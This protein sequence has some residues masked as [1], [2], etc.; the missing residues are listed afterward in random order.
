MK[1]E[2]VLWFIKNIA[3]R[4]EI[5]FDTPG[6]ITEE[7]TDKGK[8][9]KIRNFLVPEIFISDLEKKMDPQ[10]SYEIGKKFGY[11]YAQLI[12]APRIT[13][14]NPQLFASFLYF[15]VRY[16]GSLLAS[17]ASHTW[18]AQNRIFSL[19]MKDYVVCSKNGL[20]YILTEGT[21]AGTCAYMFDDV[22]IE[23][24]Q[25]KCQGRGDSECFLVA[26]S[27]E[28]LEKDGMKPL[29][30]PDV[31]KNF[32]YD[33][34]YEHM[35]SIHIPKWG[36]NSFKKL[37]DSGFLSFGYGKMEY[38]KERF[39]LFEASLLYILEDELTKHD[40]K[41]QSLLDTLWDVSFE[42]GE[43]LGKLSLEAKDGCKFI[44]DFFPALGYGDMMA[45]KSKGKY[46]VIINYFPWL[47]LAKNI[48]FTSIQGMLSGVL[49]AFE[50]RKIELKK[51]EK[52]ERNGYLTLVIS[53]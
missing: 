17:S 20:G 8:R 3:M 6:F 48:N 15:F 30:C 32:D 42:Y 18:D 13:S 7:F 4:E 43:H 45:S 29:S 36:R 44:M 34:E 33:A 49:S 12:G 1:D 16:A 5:K 14:T 9:L 26:S 46:E 23:A 31:G 51:I 40:S 53:E 52:E 41:D 27:K 2:I 35:N 50:N 10:I 22:N 24:V 21:I 11:S 39:M 25:T 19:K 38:K 37:W 28:Q 47:P